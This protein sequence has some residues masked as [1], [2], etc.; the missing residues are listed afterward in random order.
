[1]TSILFKTLGGAGADV[2]LIHGF[3]SDRL[4]WLANSTAMMAYSRVH[5]LDLPGHG[6]SPAETGDGSLQWIT[7]SVVK[8][9]TEHHI[10]AV[11]LVGHSLGGGL[12]LLIARGEPKRVRS[13]SLI[14][15]AGLGAGVDKGFLAD[16]P[17]LDKTEAAAI[18]LRRLVHQPQL[19]N[20]MTVQRALTLLGRD[21]VR[22]ALRRIA[23]ALAAGEA[24]LALAADIVAGFDL[25]RF[26]IWGEAD[27]INPPDQQRL[28]Q[29]GGEQLVVA[30][31]G[32][33]PHIEAPKVINGA[34]EA[35]LKRAMAG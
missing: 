21:G 32:H 6:D 30:E 31:A 7:D 9:F 19:I 5:A 15:P 10:G 33:L 2:V 35:F 16:Y 11:H 12:A 4:S 24:D 20:K 3:G 27:A 1:M 34:L 25:P 18:L 17:E 29:F 23:E 26:T 22:P 28:S 14:A 13:L 8:A